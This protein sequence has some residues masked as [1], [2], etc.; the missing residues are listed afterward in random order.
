MTPLP[1]AVAAALEAQRVAR[2]TA[3]AAG[4]PAPRDH[5]AAVAAAAWVLRQG[6]RL[7]AYGGPAGTVV[8]SRLTSEPSEITRK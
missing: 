5:T 6:G 3:R 7:V 1:P 8:V 4:A 2:S